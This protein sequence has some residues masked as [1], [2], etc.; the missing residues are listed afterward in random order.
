MNEA[1]RNS[2]KKKHTHRIEEDEDG[3]KSKREKNVHQAYKRRPT[4]DTE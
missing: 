3:R 2:D 4:N 1:K